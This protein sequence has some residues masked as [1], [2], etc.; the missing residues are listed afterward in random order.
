MV[1]SKVD[2]ECCS[3]LQLKLEVNT[4]TINRGKSTGS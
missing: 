2:T 1:E 4:V 3:K